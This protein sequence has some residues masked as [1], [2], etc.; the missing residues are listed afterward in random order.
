MVKTDIGYIICESYA[1]PEVVNKNVKM[2]NG[3]VVAEVIL[4]RANEKN[5]NGRFYSREEL[6]PQLNCPRIQELIR[7]GTLRAEMGHPLSADLQRQSTIDDT[8]TCARFLKLWNDG[9]LI[10]A[11]AVGTN[12]EYGRAFDLDLKEG[13]LPAWS[14]R[15]LGSI[16]NTPR[17]AEVK[18]LRIITWDNVI[19]PSHPGAYTQR[20]VTEAMNLNESTI[21]DERKKVLP[22]NESLIVP[23]TNN[24]VV[25][26][27]AAQSS[28]LKFVKECCDFMYKDL[29]ISENGSKVI[30]TTELG[31]TLVINM[32]SYIH[33]E[34]MTYAD[35]FKNKFEY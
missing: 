35:E 16:E 2:I 32:E 33:N 18:N 14:L 23:I 9:D 7:T 21:I 34:L 17:G 28:N 10:M 27:L 5:R 4:Q 11:H 24:K 3:K 12:N 31:E 1:E 20:L 29:Q 25:N 30:L 19:Y 26:F 13:C 15:A 6:I 8:K 22:Y